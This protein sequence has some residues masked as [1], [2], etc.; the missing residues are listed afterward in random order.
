MSIYWLASNF[1]T[2]S[3]IS[4][5][6]DQDTAINGNEHYIEV[7]QS[8]GRQLGRLQQLHVDHR[9]VPAGKYYV[10]G[11]IWSNGKPTFSH[12]TQ[13]ITI[14]AALTVDAS[15]APSGNVSA[16]TKTQLQPII[17]EAERR[18]TAATGIQVAAAMTGVSIQIGDLPG[19]TL[20]EAAANAI[21][22]DRTAA[23]YGW[24]V[25]P[26]PGDDSEFTDSLGPYALAAPSGT[27]AANRVDLLT[28]VMHEMTHLLGYGHSDSL[29]L[30]NPTLP[31]GERRLFDDQLLPSLSSSSRS[32]SFYTPLAETN[33]VDQVFASNWRRQKLGLAVIQ[34]P[35]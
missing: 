31:L 22:I 35:A 3:T 7:E 16:L 25:D 13:P 4:L 19:K 12:L 9:G 2:G 5:C 11:Y 24:F 32:G 30:M 27:P 10:G 26:T 34:E 15:T 23:G 20:G 21:Y 33:A 14:A 29:D 17:V 1:A 18:L 6:Y 8:D 28:T